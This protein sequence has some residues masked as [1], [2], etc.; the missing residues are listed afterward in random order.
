MLR[1]K[2]LRILLTILLGLTMIFSFGCF[3]EDDDE[4]TGP[5]GDNLV[6]EL[7]GSWYRY[8]MMDGDDNIYKTSKVLLEADGDGTEWTVEIESN[9]LTEVTHQFEIITDGPSVEVDAVD[10]DYDWSGSYNVSNGLCTFT[11][12]TE[13]RDVFVK[14]STEIDTNIVGEWNFESGTVNGLQNNA[15]GSFTINADGTGSMD[16]GEGDIPGTWFVNGDYLV[17]IG[18]DNPNYEFYVCRYN[19]TSDSAHLMITFYMSQ[20]DGNDWEYLEV[21]STYTKQTSSNID[22]DLVA[23]WHSFS[24]EIDGVTHGFDYTAIMNDDGT[25]TTIGYDDADEVEVYQFIWTA[26]GTSTSIY[27]EDGTT[28][29]WTASYTIE[30][31]VVTFTQTSGD[32][33][34]RINEMVKYTG[35]NDAG[36][37][38]TWAPYGYYEDDVFK[39]TYLL[40][41]LNADATGSDLVWDDENE[42]METETYSWSTTGRYIISS[43]DPETGEQVFPATVYSYG[44][45]ESNNTVTIDFYDDETNIFLEFVKVTGDLSSELVG[46]WDATSRTVDNVDDTDFAGSVTVTLDD[47]GTGDSTFDNETVDYDWSSNANYLIIEL[48]FMNGPAIAYSYTIADNE[49]TLTFTTSEYGPVQNIVEVYTKQ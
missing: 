38:G 46:L 29:Q 10:D 13:Y 43:L 30:E 34:G 27:E 11:D 45:T 18:D 44:L 5:T 8:S 41:T 20:L 42:E 3:G 47:D 2:D 49:L 40:T 12:D 6:E 23:T 19:L 28:L 25:G 7:Q 39:T 1:Q 16:N 48:D 32:D 21:Q 36:L 26:N 15:Q 22:P 14:A 4:P 9:D 35:E 24:S 31:D 33:I 17:M 37:V